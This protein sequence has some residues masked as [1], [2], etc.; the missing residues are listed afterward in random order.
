MPGRAQAVME[1]RTIPMARLIARDKYLYDGD[2]KFYATGVSYGPFVP[3]SRG[4]RYPEPE[5]CAQ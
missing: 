4:E 2:P 5:R 3:N 1:S